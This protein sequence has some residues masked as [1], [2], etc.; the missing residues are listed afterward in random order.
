MVI[1]EMTEGE[2]RAMLARMACRSAGVRPEQP[3]VHCSLSRRPGRRV[4][5]G[6]ATLGQKIEWMR[7]NPLVCLEIDE[8]MTDGQWASVVVFGQYEE[9]PNTPEMGVRER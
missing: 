3:T 6:F 8:L 4:P 5:H 2:C 7:Q 9:L 1:H